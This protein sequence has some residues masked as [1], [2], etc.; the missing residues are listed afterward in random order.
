MASVPSGGGGGPAVAAVAGAGAGAADVAESKIEE[1]EEEKEEEDEVRVS[2][3]YFFIPCNSIVF[4]DTLE[5]HLHMILAYLCIL[6]V[7]GHGF[8]PL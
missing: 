3:R 4:S 6:L 1:K 5:Y 8:Q 7:A 2:N